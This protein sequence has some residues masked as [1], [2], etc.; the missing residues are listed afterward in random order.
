MEYH[1]EGTSSKTLKIYETL[2]PEP[3]QILFVEA[4]KATPTASVTT[5]SGEES[6]RNN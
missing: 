6:G 4:R 2:Q 1:A 5:H 3:L